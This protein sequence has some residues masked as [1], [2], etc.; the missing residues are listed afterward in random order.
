MLGL[1]VDFRCFGLGA[2]RAEAVVQP[3]VA[4]AAALGVEGIVTGLDGV[5]ERLEGIDL[6]VGGGGEAADP[7]IEVLRP[8]DAECL[9]GTEGGKDTRGA[10]G[11]G[12]LT[13]V[14]RSPVDRRWA[15]AGP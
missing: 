10:G 14:A 8:M 6:G 4:E 7:D 13:V 11:G 1:F 15:E 9:V 5:E 2:G 12:D 3:V